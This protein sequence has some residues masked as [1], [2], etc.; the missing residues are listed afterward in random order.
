MVLLDMWTIV[1]I[2]V[3]TNIVSSI[4]VT[5]LWLHYHNRYKG[6][7]YLIYAFSLQTIAYILIILRG[8]IPLWL[9]I[10]VANA[11]SLLGMLLAFIGLEAYTG[12]KSSQ[13][14]NIILLIVFAFIHTW[15]TYVK[16]ELTMRY[17]LI[18]VASM[19]FFAQCAWLM[20]YRAPDR[21]RKL[22]KFP[23]LIFVGFCVVCLAKVIEFFVSTYKP[24]DYFQSD[25][26][27][28][29]VMISYQMLII[30]L[31]FSLALM[32]SRHLLGDIQTEEEKFSTAFNTS[33]N[34]IVITRFPGGQILEVNS[35]FLELSG[36]KYSDVIGKTTNE[37]KIWKSEN[38]RQI[39]MD[40]LSDSRRINKKE[41]KFRKK[42]GEIITG[43]LSAEVI[44]I[45]GEKCLLAS[46]DDITD[47]KKYQELIKH[48][49]NLL[50]TL[51]DHLPDPVTIKDFEGRYLLNNRAHLK[52]IG[53]E[54]QE[55]AIGKTSYAFFPETEASE[56]NRE[57]KE[58]MLSGK[59]ILEKVECAE[60]KETGSLYW[61]MTSRIPIRDN[62]GKSNQILTISHDITESK[63]NEKELI[64][65]KEKAEE[66]D[67]LKT[68]FLHNIS[69][70]I[71]TPMNAIIGFSALLDD[72]DITPENRALY[73][74]TLQLSSN[75]L[76]S[77]I[78]DIINIS[79]IEANIIKIKES[80]TDIIPMLVRLYEKFLP[81]TTI[82][83]LTLSWATTL[84]GEKAIIMA[85]NE[86]LFEILSNLID[87]ALKFTEH[88]E[89]KFGCDIEDSF[90][91]FYVSDTGIGISEDQLTK[92]F[93]H[94]YQV[95]HT[96]SRLYEGT[97]IGLSISKAYIEL[98][99]GKIWVRSE[100]GKGSVFYFTIP[101]KH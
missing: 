19:T 80:G 91:R 70:E 101:Y 15:Y 17:L 43:L 74:N 57:E 25:M 67:R 10:D 37:I 92:I 76:L 26:F 96:N 83:N 98:L 78:T 94:F 49:R 8:M 23:G 40:Q 47:H 56:Y 87:N 52:V 41:V 72:P 86:K 73:I 32:F 39:I 75:H 61:H 89:I 29:I 44:T 88:G 16:P 100:K 77:L 51:I 85:D 18:S 13:M 90:L 36:Y 38:E 33:P 63:L 64:K 82:K 42:S 97:G 55:E 24:V 48:E 54:S 6:I 84:A 21:M 50:R 46:I 14:L 59:S 95:D 45:A 71:R 93:D 12:K 65:A 20:L 28:A 7:G 27:E 66:S 69:H 2:F 99:G 4:V 11:L 60:Y 3:L 68:A 58:V 34:A 30:M 62:T 35:V 31:T 1:L 81:A 5:L 9:S 53:V 22:T 79:N